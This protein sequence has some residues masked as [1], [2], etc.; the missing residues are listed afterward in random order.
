MDAMKDN[1]RWFF[2]VSCKDDMGLAVGA[3]Y[4][5]TL[6]LWSAALQALVV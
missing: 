2:T 3:L 4:I 6:V 1:E 5:P